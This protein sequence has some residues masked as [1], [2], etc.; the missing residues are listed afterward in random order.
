MTTSVTGKKYDVGG[1]LLNQPFKIRRLGHFGFNGVKVD[2]CMKFYTDL[3]GFRV[4]DPWSDGGA[5][6]RYGNDH[7]AFVLFNKVTGDERAKNGPNK[8]HWRYENDVN[9]ITWQVQSLTEMVDA[10]DYFRE[11]GIDIRSEG[12]AGGPG[13]N[14]HLYV[15][16]PDEQIDEFYYGIAQVGW[17]GVSQPEDM[18][19]GMQKASHDPHIP[20]YMEVDIDL[21]EGKEVTKGYRWLENMEPKYDVS[22]ILLGR[23]FKVTRIGPVKNFVDDLDVSRRYYEDVLGF[24]VT[25]E[26][27]YQGE[28]GVLLR[29]DNEHHSLGL[30]EKGLRSK[31]G[32]KDDSSNMSFGLQVA[33][34]QQ[35]KDAVSF[36]RENG[37]RVETDI[38]PPELHPGIDYAAYAFDPDGHA[39]ELYYSMEQVGWD[40]KARPASSRPKVDPNNWPEAV[41]GNSDSFAG[42]PFMGPWG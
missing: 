33:N 40:G 34:Y 14:Y 18:R 41:E 23:P 38:I 15:W 32:L 31:L 25:E 8:H 29:C 26:V 5:F 39:L 19:H 24:E 16:D 4:S 3:L 27:E 21:A 37:V 22:G 2:E 42:E 12:R 30:F 7:H 13:S 35:L 1:V 11:L 20:E 28:R 9:Q 6:M 10:T 17:T 36:L